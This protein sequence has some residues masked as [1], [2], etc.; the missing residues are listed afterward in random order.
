M[1]LTNG[2]I[3]ICD[4]NGN[5]RIKE[6]DLWKECEPI[7]SLSAEDEPKSYKMTD[8]SLL[9]TS[10]EEWKDIWEEHIKFRDIV[11]KKN[12]FEHNRGR[13]VFVHFEHYIENIHLKMKLLKLEKRLQKLEIHMK[14]K[15]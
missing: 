6:V 5:P 14:F 3:I 10:E 11:L 1:N 4:I 2:R 12:R 13:T 7:P 15:E 8:M 9:E